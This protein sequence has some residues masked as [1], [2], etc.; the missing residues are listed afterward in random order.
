MFSFQAAKRGRQHLQDAVQREALLLED[1]YVNKTC[2]DS[3]PFDED[4]VAQ[5]YLDRYHFK[6]GT[7][8]RATGDGDCLFNAAS[9]ILCGD[10][11]MGTELKYKCC[12]EMV[13]NGKEIQN[14]RDRAA[15]VLLSPDY[16]DAVLKCVRSGGYSCVWT[17]IALSNVTKHNIETLYPLING[18]KDL[19]ARTMNTMITPSS[20]LTEDKP[21]KIMWTHTLSKTPSAKKSW[22]P[23][24]F[25][26][27]ID[28][29]KILHKGISA[30]T[31]TP[32]DKAASVIFIPKHPTQGDRPWRTQRKRSKPLSPIRTVESDIHCF[33]RFENL[34]DSEDCNDPDFQCSSTSSSTDSDSGSAGQQQPSKR[35]KTN[36]K[37]R[38]KPQCPP[39]SVGEELMDT[40][41]QDEPDNSLPSPRQSH[42]DTFVQKDTSVS[43]AW[44]SGEDSSRVEPK[45]SKITSSMMPLPNPGRFLSPEEQLEILRSTENVATKVPP[46]N[47]SNSYVIVDDSVNREKRSNNIRSD[48]VDDCGVWDSSTGNTVNIHFMITD[49][50]HCRLRTIFLKDGIFCTEKRSKYGNKTTQ[51]WNP[52]HPQPTEQNLVKIHRYY[53]KQKGNHTFKKRVTTFEKLPS[54]F[55][56]KTN[57]AFIEYCGQQEKISRPHGNSQD[58]DEHYTR[59]DPLILHQANQ[60]TK[61]KKPTE[62][63]NMM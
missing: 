57:F 7:T 5:H 4:S 43:C 28:D 23:N 38:T 56:S 58:K 48:F 34:S 13:L 54:K 20:G 50:K 61:D 37:K 16:E 22:T 15:I 62:I 30:K 14:H 11:S 29:P 63:M 3:I 1:R 18:P 25:V 45:F 60:L 42:H 35:R 12:I 44:N 51:L 40:S 19:A 49:E 21:M 27:L 2:S 26:P 36:K 47:K 8:L 17:I 24:H 41:I 33:N 53:T 10:E 59:T 6:S 55:E 46:G 31:S 52:I 39:R 9:I 32:A